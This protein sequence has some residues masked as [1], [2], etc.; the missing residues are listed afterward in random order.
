M[1][2]WGYLI[3]SIVVALTMGVVIGVGLERSRWSD[4]G[5]RGTCIFC[6]EDWWFVVPERDYHDM[7]R[8]LHDN[9]SLDRVR[10]QAQHQPSKETPG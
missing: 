10:A 7:K 6:E 8:A 3:L 5:K 4:A 9:P 2:F 1:P